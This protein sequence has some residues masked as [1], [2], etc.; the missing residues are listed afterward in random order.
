MMTRQPRTYVLLGTNFRMSG[1]PK[2]HVSSRQ[3]FGGKDSDRS[4]ALLSAR[5]RHSLKGDSLRRSN[6]PLSRTEQLILLVLRMNVMVT[7]TVRG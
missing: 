3:V 5:M 7:L 1:E 4:F 2:W 6:T